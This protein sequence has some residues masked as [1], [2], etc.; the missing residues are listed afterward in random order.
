MSE[1]F[2]LMVLF[3]AVALWWKL[4]STREHALTAAKRHCAEVGVQFL[5]G[6]VMSNGIRISRNASGNLTLVQKFRFE[7]S[8]SGDQRYWGL[9]EMMGR[10]VVKMELEAHRV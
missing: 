6:S 7:F 9:T 8:T 5:D 3:V 4:S 2:F 10:R 1:L